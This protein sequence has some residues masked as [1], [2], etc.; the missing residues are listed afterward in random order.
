M[1]RCAYRIDTCIDTGA[2]PG[3]RADDM[4]RESNRN[5]IPKGA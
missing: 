2:L 1:F 5:R 4:A 3:A